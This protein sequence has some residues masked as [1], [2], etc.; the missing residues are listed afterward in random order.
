MSAWHCSSC[1]GLVENLTDR[2]LLI[3]LQGEKGFGRIK[4]SV[5]S[6]GVSR[7]EE[8]AWY[9]AGGIAFVNGTAFH[10]DDFLNARPKLTLLE[11]I[12]SWKYLTVVLSIAMALMCIPIITTLV[13]VIKKRCSGAPSSSRNR[14][15]QRPQTRT[16]ALDSLDASAEDLAAIRMLERLQATAGLEW[17]SDSHA[18]SCG[19][20][21]NRYGVA[22]EKLNWLVVLCAGMP[23]L[24]LHQPAKRSAV[25]DVPKLP[26]SGGSHRPAE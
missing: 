19:Y 11:K 12:L 4:R 7:M 17:V 10:N 8:Y 15:G 24:H 3:H 1:D 6:C 2:G 5:G 13:R 20:M 14:G 9:G 25:R 23:V 26:G 22:H 16:V 21:S 18:R